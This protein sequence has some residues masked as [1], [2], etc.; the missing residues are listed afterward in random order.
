DLTQITNVSISQNDLTDLLPI[1]LRWKAVE[2]TKFYR[3]EVE[4][5]AHKTIFSAIV[6]PT[7]LEYQLPSFIKSLTAARQLKWRV[8]A[9][10]EDAQP[11]DT[12]SFIEIAKN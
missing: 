3:I 11:L 8:L 10:G 6:L 7:G 12:S 4:D 2:K 9:I 5:E 1:C